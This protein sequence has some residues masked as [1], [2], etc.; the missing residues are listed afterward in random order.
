[1]SSLFL[2]II[3][4]VPAIVAATLLAP[5]LGVLLMI[6]RYIVSDSKKDRRGSISI[7]IIGLLILIPRWLFLLSE[8][9]HFDMA[10]SAFL[11]NIVN[12]QFYMERVTTCG[13][14]LIVLGIVSLIVSIL[15]NNLLARFKNMLSGAI[16]RNEVKHAEIEKENNFRVKEMEYKAQHSHVVTC[17]KCGA[18]NTIVGDTGVCG[19]C[20]QSLSSK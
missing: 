11:K 10:V 14:T 18:N 12:N 17:P 15:F 9:L 16:E 6:L 2:K 1:M 3:V 13:F 20:R 8:G 7:I 4:S 19:Y 5:A